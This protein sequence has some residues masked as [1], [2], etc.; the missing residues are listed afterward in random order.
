MTYELAKKLKDLGFPQYYEKK[1]RM[2]FFSGDDNK[3]GEDIYSPD[4]SELIEAC[5]DKFFELQ[6]DT[7]GGW[8]AHDHESP[9][10]STS[11]LT[12]EEAVANLWLALNTKVD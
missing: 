1:P 2:A 10:C 7:D 9:V 3:S 5:G 12:P 4:L 6:R 8:C 11:G